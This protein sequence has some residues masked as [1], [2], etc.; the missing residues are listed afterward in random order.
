MCRHGDMCTAHSLV[1]HLGR[2]LL[3]NICHMLTREGAADG[4]EPGQES[5]GAAMAAYATRAG[6]LFRLAALLKRYADEYQ[7]AVV[8]TNQVCALACT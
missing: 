7:L 1:R 2:A 3:I 5:G 6:L 4:G 8:V